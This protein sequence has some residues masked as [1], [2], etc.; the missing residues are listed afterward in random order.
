MKYI[1]VNEAQET[2]D[3]IRAEYVAPT[4]HGQVLF[5]LPEIDMTKIFGNRQRMD[6]EKVAAQICRIVTESFQA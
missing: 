4:F 1:K 5:S 6:A 2:Y 3:R